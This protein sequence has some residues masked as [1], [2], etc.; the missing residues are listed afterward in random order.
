MELPVL[1]Q[2][3]DVPLCTGDMAEDV[4]RL[5]QRRQAERITGKLM[6]PSKMDVPSWG[7]PATRCCIGSALAGIPGSTCASCYA[8]K[9][10]FLFPNVQQKLEKAYEAMFH[11]DWTPAMVVMINWYA[12]DRFR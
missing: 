3:R 6:Y 9:G 8:L 10:T 11:K 2:H 12:N 5:S 1:G 7:I 4:L